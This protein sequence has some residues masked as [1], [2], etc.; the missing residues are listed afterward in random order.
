MRSVQRATIA[1]FFAMCAPFVGAQQGVPTGYVETG[2]ARRDVR[3]AILS[4]PAVLRDGDRR[5]LDGGSTLLRVEDIGPLRYYQFM[6]VVDGVP[7]LLMPG[8]AIIRERI[9]D[10]T[11]EQ[12]KIFTQR[13]EGSFIRVTPSG[14]GTSLELVLAGA[15]LYSSVPM[16]LTMDQAIAAPL[17]VI[18]R[19][20][21]AQVR[22]DLLVPDLFDPGHARVAFMVEQM[23]AVLDALPDAEDGA[24]DS[25]GRIV[26]IEDLAF[27]E[28]LPG[29]NCSG[30]A[31]YVVDGIVAPQMGRLLEIAPLREKHLDYRGT[32]W[33]EPLEEARDP[34]FGLDWTRNLARAAAAADEGRAIESIA[35][36]AFDVRRSPFAAYVE[37]AG[38]PVESLRA[39]LYWLALTEP[40]TIYLGSV[41]RPFEARQ[42]L[43]QHSHVVV[44]FPYFDRDGVLQ[45]VVME[46]NVES[47]VSSLERRYAGD[48]VHLVRVA[49]GSR[50]E[51]PV[52]AR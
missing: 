15:P 47:S 6:P 46:R 17:D 24:M 3:D 13:D 50:F 31:K 43:R 23:R 38:F 16:A 12:I 7:S 41:N 44:F 21:S 8:A 48:F 30:F 36:E 4:Q 45:S 39:T 28:E 5:V 49:A 9:G 19:T 34:Y 40:G 1:L 11:I 25:S 51:P 29:F 26:F 37:D 32:A 2:S 18:M 10:R 42:T 27:M 22:W 35:P 52:V 20:T 14:R 33:S